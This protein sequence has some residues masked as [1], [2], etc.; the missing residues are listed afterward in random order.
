MVRE[1]SIITARRLY[2]GSHLVDS[3]KLKTPTPAWQEPA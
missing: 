2:D 1:L 3:G